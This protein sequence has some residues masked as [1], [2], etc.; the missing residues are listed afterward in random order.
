[1]AFLSSVVGKSIDEGFASC[2]FI[3]NKGHAYLSIISFLKFR[4][5]ISFGLIF[6]L[7]YLCCISM[8]SQTKT[9]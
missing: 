5:E 6:R 7:S 3:T 2:D 1:M 9:F 4:P 8:Y